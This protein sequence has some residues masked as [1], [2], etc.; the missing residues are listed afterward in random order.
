MKIYKLEYLPVVLKDMLDIVK[1]IGNELK[2]PAAAENLANEFI[3]SAESLT[4]FPYSNPVYYPIR[5][6]KNEYRKLIVKNFIMFYYVDEPKKTITIARV[7][8]V[9]RDCGRILE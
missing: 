4:E 6:L 5:P 8:Y 1:Y 7:I 3:E 9:K 2:N